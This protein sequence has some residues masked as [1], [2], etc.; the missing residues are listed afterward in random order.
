V[1]AGGHKKFRIYP[2]SK[3]EHLDEKQS[4]KLYS[5]LLGPLGYREIRR[6]LKEELGVSTSLPA[7]SKFYRRNV[8]QHVIALRQQSVEKALRYKNETDKS[9]GHFSKAA[10][11]AFEQKAVEACYDPS[12]SPKDLTVYLELLLRWQEQKIREA[13]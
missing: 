11:D 1:N 4:R 13:R 2:T 5:W 9:L 6:K 3:L 7:I 12:T 10:F 8:L